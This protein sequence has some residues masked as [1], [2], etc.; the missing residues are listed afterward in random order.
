MRTVF[1]SHFD[2]SGRGSFLTG[3]QCD[4]GSVLG[5]VTERMRGIERGGVDE[6]MLVTRMDFLHLFFLILILFHVLLPLLPHGLLDFLTG[7]LVR[8]FLLGYIIPCP[9]SLALQISCVLEHLD[10]FFV[11]FFPS[12]V[13]QGGTET[14]SVGLLAVIH[15]THCM[16]GDK[17]QQ[18][19][20]HDL[21]HNCIGF[22]DWF[23]GFVRDPQIHRR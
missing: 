4:K 10:E 8:K 6:E 18:D 16:V 14:E 20:C 5:I 23:M 2:V 13:T 17:G 19:D 7:I 1:F 3:T 15:L 21:F 9:P 11:D 12:L 22:S